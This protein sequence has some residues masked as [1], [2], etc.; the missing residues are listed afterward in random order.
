MGVVARMN[1]C[2]L[3]HSPETGQ[4]VLQS[5]PVGPFKIGV[6][7]ALKLWRKHSRRGTCR[8]LGIEVS[9]RTRAGGDI[10]VL[11]GLC[12]EGGAQQP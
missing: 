5:E 9:R 7:A 3:P 2:E 4:I 11:W 10:G 8:R 12:D 6:G 1:L